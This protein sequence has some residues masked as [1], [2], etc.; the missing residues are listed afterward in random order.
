L[1]LIN[2]VEVQASDVS[3]YIIRGKLIRIKVIDD[4]SNFFLLVKSFE[5]PVLG[6]SGI[7][8]HVCVESEEV[9]T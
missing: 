9:M 6:V 7:C 1:E 4:A 2:D 3:H 5:H 8:D